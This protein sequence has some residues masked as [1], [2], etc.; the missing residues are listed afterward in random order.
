[1]DCTDIKVILSGLVDDELDGETRHDA[2]RHLAEC[3]PCRN[4]VSQAEGLNAL[5][6]LDAQSMIEPRLPEDFE[7]A[8]L[9]RPIYPQTYK[10]RARRKMWPTYVGWL[11]AAACIALAS[12]IWMERQPQRGQDIAIGPAPIVYH[13]GTGLRSST[14]DGDQPIKQLA[15]TGDPDD[16]DTLYAASLALSMLHDA[17]LNS[18]ADVDKVRRI[19]EY[20]DLLDRLAAT[21]QRLPERDRPVLLAAEG[22]LSRTVLGPVSQQD[23]R[24]LH[25]IVARMELPRVLDEMSKREQT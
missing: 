8:V 7:A 18:F 3:Q 11:A 9:S 20:D 16:A 24:D 22:V 15:A 17:D 5:V 6:A 10:F 12:L 1:M 4:L 2:E 25:D 19:A 23:L 21:R 13:T 14:F